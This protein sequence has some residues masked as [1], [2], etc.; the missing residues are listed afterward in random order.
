MKRYFILQNV[1]IIYFPSGSEN[2]DLEPYVKRISSILKG[3]YSFPKGITE[4]FDFLF[5]GDEEDA[6]NLS[7]L[8]SRGITHVINCASSYI[9]TG[10]D[11]YN[12]SI[13][14]YFYNVICISLLFKTK[15]L[16]FCFLLVI[17]G[18]FSSSVSTKIS[19]YNQ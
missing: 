12:S 13:K 8:E 1:P 2:E 18:I 14:R 3:Y 4:I 11:F 7:L 9:D 10:N 17:Y 5:L 15:K 6:R 16:F 19:K